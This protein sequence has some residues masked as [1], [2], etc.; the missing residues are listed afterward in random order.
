MIDYLIPP[1]QEKTPIVRLRSVDRFMIGN[2][3]YIPA[4][5]LL[6]GYNFVSEENRDQSFPLTHLE[7]FK[8]LDEKKAKI[9]RPETRTSSK[10]LLIYRGKTFDDFTPKQQL[11]GRKLKKLIDRYDAAKL[12]GEKLPRSD[13]NPS[14]SFQIWLNEESR[15]L[16]YRLKQ[17]GEPT[18][19]KLISR[20]Q[21]NRQYERYVQGG[22]NILSIMPRHSGPGR[23]TAAEWTPES[24]D[25][26]L[27]EAQSFKSELQPKKS[28]VYDWYKAALWAE[29]ERRKSAKEPELYE[30]GRTAFSDIIDSFPAFDVMA[31]RF[32][33]A[34]AREHFMLNMASYQDVRPGSLVQ[35]DEWKGDMMTLVAKMGQ[36]KAIPPKLHKFLKKIRIWLVVAICVATRAILAIHAVP[37]PNTQAAIDT[38]KMIMSDK[39]RYA[40]LAGAQSGWRQRARPEELHIDNG[41][42]FIS[43][44]FADVMDALCI[45][46]TFPPARKPKKRPHIESL[47]HVIGPRLTGFFHGRTFSNIIEKGDYD[48][49]KHASLIIGEFVNAFRLGALDVYH[50][51]AHG[52][53]GGR[54]P[55][56]VWID[57]AS[58]YEWDYPPT[59][60]EMLHAF[61]QTRSAVVGSYGIVLRDISYWNDELVR[62]F[63]D[64]GN[65][66]VR[67]KDNASNVGSILVQGNDGKWFEVENRSGVE[68]GVTAEEWNEARRQLRQQNKEETDRDLPI[69]YGATNRLREMAREVAE[70]SGLPPIVKPQQKIEQARGQ[71]FTGYNEGP[72]PGTTRPTVGEAF[73]ELRS[74]ATPTAPVSPDAP[75]TSQ[76][77]AP[78]ISKFDRVKDED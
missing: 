40:E 32:G 2:D 35:M 20:S 63:M 7:I 71:V 21:F 1:S 33:E 50:M 61:G 37:K 52:S 49:R 22:R 77:P 5:R 42:A 51:S 59:A 15:Q 56:N 38:L 29:N 62:H 69:V 66:P 12:R 23:K 24:Y 14:S 11:E 43:E 45:R 53:L 18:A 44:R 76:P 28:E 58:N 39:T 36:Y 60:G 48:P 64:V 19:D 17:Q 75:S 8:L 54:S 13:R 26:A 73:D 34:Y 78:G 55:H 57:A 41:S 6:T 68:D 74:A 65:T 27:F 16:N 4:G 72:E 46:P 25:F 30:F 31:G 3:A 9:L 67:I 10:L 70:R 47:F